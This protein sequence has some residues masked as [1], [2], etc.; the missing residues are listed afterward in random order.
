MASARADGVRI[1]FVQPQFDS[2]SADAVARAIDGVVVPMDPLARDVLK[3]LQDMATKIASA[4]G[5]ADPPR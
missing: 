1:I 3:N 5:G 2:K 4:L